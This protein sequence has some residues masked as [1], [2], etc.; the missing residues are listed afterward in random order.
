MATTTASP[1]RTGSRQTPSRQTPT[2]QTPLSARA[3]K[4]D[5]ANVKQF[6]MPFDRKNIMIILAGV[7]IVALGYLV[8]YMSPTMSDMALTVAPILLVLGYCV[9]IP[10]GI[11]AG[12]RGKRA[13]ATTISEPTANGTI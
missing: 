4:K 7:A 9:I 1:V 5:Y 6:Q 8:M 11:M 10:F 3:K 13:A 12:V 2:R